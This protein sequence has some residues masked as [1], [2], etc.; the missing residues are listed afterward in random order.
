M[1]SKKDLTAQIRS[2][3][4][5]CSRCG[6]WCRGVSPDSDLVMVSPD[7]VKPIVSSTGRAWDRIA[8]PYPETITDRSGA[9]FTIGWCLRRENGRCC[10]L[11]KGTCMIYNNRPWIC[12]AYPFALD[13][14]TMG[15]SPCEGAGEPVSW[16]EAGT[17]AEEN[18]LAHRHAKK[19]EEMNV[20]KVIGE[21]S[22]PAGVFVVIDAD[23]VRVIDG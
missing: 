22:F 14:D 12:R 4:F 17:I 7:E 8:E 3:G 1:V 5:A 15:V 13:N 9:R 21:V 16:Q 10:F 11:D 18:L 19:E 2:I 20:Q 23:G 6:T